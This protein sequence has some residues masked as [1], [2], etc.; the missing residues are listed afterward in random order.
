MVSKL[1]DRPRKSRL[2]R[3]EV[4]EDEAAGR[5]I[6]MSYKSAKEEYGDRLLIG[7]LGV[8]EEGSEKIA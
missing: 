1:S 3:G 2:H 5:M 8:V 7:A 6:R 4:K